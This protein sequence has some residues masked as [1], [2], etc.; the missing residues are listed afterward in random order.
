MPIIQEFTGTLV[1]RHV[2]ASGFASE[3]SVSGTTVRPFGLG[4]ADVNIRCMLTSFAANNTLPG[5]AGIGV[6]SFTSFDAAGIL[7]TTSNGPNSSG[8]PA[9]AELKNCTSFTVSLGVIRCD[10][11]GSWVVQRW[12]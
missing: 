10:A 9:F 6:S 11:K 8:W 2:K 7:R 12:G 4:R 1:A 5:G 3:I